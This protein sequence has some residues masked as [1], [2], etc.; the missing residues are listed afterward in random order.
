MRIEE[1][2]AVALQAKL[3]PNPIF[4]A[5]V[6]A[7]DPGSDQ[8]FRVGSSGQKVF[9]FEQL[10]LLGGK[11]NLERKIAGTETKIAELEFQKLVRELRYRLRT[12]LF[13]ATQHELLLSK[14]DRQLTLL[15]TLL[16]NY[17]IQVDKGN[18][19]PK[20]LVRLKGAY[21]KLNNDRAEILR[22][23]R[24]SQSQLQILLN[25]QSLVKLLIR[26]TEIERYL[27]ARSENEL[28][29]IALHNVPELL[30]AETGTLLAE[31][32]IQLQKKLAIPDVNFFTS[33]DQRGGAFDNQI[34]SGIAVALPLWNRNQGN[35]RATEFRAK[36]A[37]YLLSA[38]KTEVLSSIQNSYAFYL[39]TISE[40]NKAKLLYNS[41]FELTVEGIT[42]SFRKQNISILEFLDFF[43]SYND[44][45]F[46]LARIK[47]QLVAS[48]ELL[49][50]LTGKDLFE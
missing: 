33:Y 45:M 7:Y 32:Q 25:T 48:G 41:D 27:N 14:Y 49:S 22:D 10:I 37:S 23:Y 28:R 17:Q 42:K 16:M 21:L 5:E 31:Q 19:A 40:Y 30:I 6:N 18:I 26:E 2:K 13:A 20:D 1:Q 12:E 44:A 29:E 46:E 24:E 15:D 9:Q 35:I 38:T 50:L 36:E 11:R 34:N 39:Q 47:T 43:E 4:T 8:A 3:Y